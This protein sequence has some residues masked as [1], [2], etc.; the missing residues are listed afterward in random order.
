[1]TNQTL[2]EKHVDRT[3]QGILDAAF[4]LFGERGFSATTV[5]DIAARADVAP[6]TFFRYFPS[7]ESV[8][9]TGNEIKPEV[10]KQ[11][12]AERPEGESPAESM[13][14]VLLHLPEALAGDSQEISLLCA[15]AAQNSGI[16]ASLRNAFIEQF[17][18][19]AVEFLA[20]RHGLSP[21]DVGL[22][23]MAATI[24]SCFATAVTCWLKDGAKGDIWRY[25]AEGL[26]ACRTAFSPGASVPPMSP[27]LLDSH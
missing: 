7:K 25:V 1:M 13:I 2:R 23:V 14:A 5:E 15:V 11:Q 16:L 26:A 8:L 21:N 9:F 22:Q 19:A 3:R 20:E 24:V 10:L 12:F 18:T 6:R 4:A 17:S 27:A